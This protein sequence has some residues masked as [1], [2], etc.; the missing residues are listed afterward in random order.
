MRANQGKWANMVN[1]IARI[2]AMG[3][4]YDADGGYSLIRK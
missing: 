1:G 3:E 4:P 2:I